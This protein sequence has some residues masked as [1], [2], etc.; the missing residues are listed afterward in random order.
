[1]T[2]FN[3]GYSSEINRIIPN[4]FNVLLVGLDPMQVSNLLTS[5]EMLQDYLSS[6]GQTGKIYL[7]TA[8]THETSFLGALAYDNDY[9]TNHIIDE[10]N[11][12]NVATV[13]EQK[14]I[15]IVLDENELFD[16]R[17]IHL[18][19]EKVAIVHRYRPQFTDL[20]NAICAG[21]GVVWNFREPL[22]NAS[23]ITKYLEP[24]YLN[25]KV[26]DFMFAGQRQGYSESEINLIRN[27]SNKISQLNHSKQN[28]EY[29]MILNRYAKRHETKTD[30][31]LF[32]LTYHLNSYYLLMSGT[33]DVCSRLLNSVYGLNFG[34]FQSYTLDKSLFLQRLKIK[35]K[36]LYNIIALNKYL[37]WMFWLRTR[38]NYFAH[39]GHPY[40][41]PLLQ[42]KA[43]QLSDDQ[44]N[45]LVENAMDWGLLSSV[46]S[47]EVIQGMRDFSRFQI[48]LEQNNETLVKDIMTLTRQDRLTGEAREVIF[49]PLRAVDDDYKMFSE[50]MIRIINNLDGAR[51]SIR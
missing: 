15:D 16:K 17:D 44:M 30:D 14:D 8:V 5:I 13:I 29:L 27:M 4:T 50:L 49:F 21:W 45:E 39:Q 18:I 38:R 6:L 24:N 12:E 36:S 42:R 51:R 43:V 37:D 31:I 35:R 48:D 11:K 33:L 3:G 20:L 10:V 25:R 7:H 9:L 1:M 46:G 23:W 22:L 19:R 41:T 34:D 47:P 40:L 32:Q 26:Y 28:I 2:V